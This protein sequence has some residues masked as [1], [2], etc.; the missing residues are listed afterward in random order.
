MLISI[1]PGKSGAW[2]VFDAAG[3]L[4][5]TNKLKCTEGE[6][7]FQP[8]DLS[9][10][11]M[12]MGLHS[13]EYVVMEGLLDKHMPK[14][15]PQSNNTAANWG[16]LYSFVSLHARRFEIVRPVTWKTKL[17]LSGQDKKASVAMAIEL[18][19]EEHLIKPRMRVPNEDIAEA[20]LIGIYYGRKELGWDI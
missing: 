13:P 15:S 7:F 2:A 17:G 12:Y 9:D 4:Q 1:D 5:F 16:Q 11:C 18:V 20:V 19:G 3:S 8:D 10:L 6:R 14:Q